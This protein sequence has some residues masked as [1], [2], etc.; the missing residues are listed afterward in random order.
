MTP[1]SAGWT[2]VGF[3]LHRLAPGETASG[4]STPPEPASS[5]ALRRA[6]VI[7]PSPTV[8]LLEPGAWVIRTETELVLKSRWVVPERLL[9]AGYVFRYPE[10]AAAIEAIVADR[11]TR[12]APARTPRTGHTSAFH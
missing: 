9:A 6:L 12:G 7:E 4:E 10:V 11:R 2:Y 3:D 8:R 1:E 5:P